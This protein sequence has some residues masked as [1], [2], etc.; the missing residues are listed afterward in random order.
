MP[1][2]ERVVEVIAEFGSSE[3]PSY[4]YG[5]G[6]RV[7]GRVVLTAAHVVAGAHAVLVRGVDKLEY[8][9]ELNPVFVGDPDGPGIDRA[10]IWP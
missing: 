7:A 8:H 3:E 10:P 1:L 6:C 2:A 9:A 4:R 5:S